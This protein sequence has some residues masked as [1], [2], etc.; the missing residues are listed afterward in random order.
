MCKKD[1]N[2]I[3]MTP[4]LAMMTN[5][6]KTEK[7]WKIL[8]S[9]AWGKQSLLNLRTKVLIVHFRK[10][11]VKTHPVCISGAE[12][13]QVNWYRFLGINIQVNLKVSTHLHV[14]KRRGKKAKH[15]KCCILIDFYRGA[16]ESILA[17]DIINWHGLCRSRIG[18]PFQPSN[19][20]QR[21][22][23]SLILY[24]STEH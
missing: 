7:K 13:E 20:A 15:R 6:G 17:G 9:G 12:V 18:G 5:V 11:Q 2:S 4:S 24:S 8:Q 19:T 22:R 10:K 23:T 21:P 16:I 3:Q 1:F 14:C